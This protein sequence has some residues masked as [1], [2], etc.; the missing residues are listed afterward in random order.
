MEHD[1]AV[2]GALRRFKRRETLRIAYGDIVREQSLKTVTKQI[3][4]L[5][6]AILEAALR[7]AGRKLGALRGTPMGPDG[8]PARFAVLGMGKLGGVELN[9]S[10]D[11][12]LILIYDF[13]GKTNGK[14]PISNQEF[15]DMLAREMVR[16]VTE[17]T[18]LG[19]AYRVDLRLRPEG[20]HGPIVMGM[21]AALNY[22][23]LRGRT[24]ERQAFIKARPVAGSPELGQEFLDQLT[25]WIYRRYLTAADIAGIKALKRRIEQQTHH[26]GADDREV[27][28][29]HGGIRDVEFVI[30]FLQLLNGGSLPELRTSNTLEALAQ[31]EQVGCLTNQERSLLEEN[32]SFLRKVEH[33]LQIM[34]DLQTHLLPQ[35]EAELRKLALRMGYADRPEGD[36]PIFAD[37]ASMVPEKSGRSPNAPGSVHG[38]L[39]G[40]DASE[41]QN[42]GSPAARRLQRRRDNGGRGGP[43]ARS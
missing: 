26:A 7:A 1:A 27:K 25:P 8:R 22:Y 18:E 24:W 4:F 3:S 21:E 31:L 15:F 29:G 9:Y 36:G 19:R 41:P 37:H 39:L 38:R 12:D 11:I 34:L 10:S 6:D 14:R 32:Y 43:G 5:A 13:E 40:Q 42:S 16:L 33:R 30:Q 20:E 17:P 35:D 28:T 23:D 2:L